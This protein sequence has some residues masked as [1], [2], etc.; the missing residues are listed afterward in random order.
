MDKKYLKPLAMIVLLL[1]LALITVASYAWFSASVNG[2]SSTNAITTGHMEVTYEEGSNIS[3]K[4]NMIPGDYITKTFSVTN[5]GNVDAIYNIYFNEIFNN[6]DPK[7]DLVYELISKNGANISETVCPDAKEIISAGILLGVGQTHNYTLKITFKETGVN[8]DSNK[9]KTFTGKI[10]LEDSSQEYEFVTKYY[11]YEGNFRVFD[12]LDDLK[13]TSATY[14]AIKHNLN[15][16]EY[17]TEAYSPVEYIADYDDCEDVFEYFDN[18]DVKSCEKVTSGEHA[19]Q[20]K[21]IYKP[22]FSS[23]SK[24]EE[25]IHGECE[26]VES[27]DEPTKIIGISRLFSEEMCI[28]SD[29][30]DNCVDPKNISSDQAFY[31]RLNGINGITCSTGGYYPNGYTCYGNQDSL[32]HFDEYYRKLYVM[33]YGVYNLLHSVYY[34]NEYNSLD[35]CE[36]YFDQCEEHNGKYYGVDYDGWEGSC[37]EPYYD[38]ENPNIYYYC[39]EDNYI[40]YGHYL[41]TLNNYGELSFQDLREGSIS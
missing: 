23:Q 19:N 1:I 16:F 2:N 17:S 10:D 4:E 34:E 40:E 38:S 12:S 20:L 6:F 41:M 8:Q 24:C 29:G 5:T 26:F 30:K 13:A 11:A 32:I 3:L 9:G 39:T 31:N 21:I 35:I 36:G 15:S 22:S 14:Y 27:Y 7:S 37:F 33:S 18:S 28:I 25:L